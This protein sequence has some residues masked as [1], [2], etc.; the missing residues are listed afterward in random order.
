MGSWSSLVSS[1]RHGG[2]VGASPVVAGMSQLGS[3]SRT[4][5]RPACSHACSLKAASGCRILIVP[6]SKG[7]KHVLLCARL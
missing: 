4:G 2:G 5:E 6:Q 7:H 3:E 1:Q